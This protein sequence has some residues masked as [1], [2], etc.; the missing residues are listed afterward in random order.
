VLI[1]GQR[2]LEACKKLGH[3]RI[4]AQVLDCEDVLG[5]EH[6]ENVIRKDFAPLE[7]LAIAQEI[8][9]QVR[10]RLEEK[11]KEAGKEGSKGG[12]GKKNPSENSSEG[13]HEKAADIAAKAV[14]WSAPTYRKAKKVVEVAQQH[15]DYA[16]LAEE[17][18]HTG[19]V[20]AAY[21]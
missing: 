16:D 17:M 15:E 11:Q 14:G 19:N 5:A 21:K 4:W 6:D 7:R 1:V 10:P 3:T 18:D 9:A 2:R 12:R 8:E 20:E 13:F